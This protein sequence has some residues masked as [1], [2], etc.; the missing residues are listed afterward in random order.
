MDNDWVIQQ[1]AALHDWN[2]GGAIKASFMTARHVAI[3]IDRHDVEPF[4]W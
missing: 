1:G 2:A 4:L 3:T